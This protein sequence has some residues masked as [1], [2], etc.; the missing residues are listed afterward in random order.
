[1]PPSPQ[2][3]VL[4]TLSEKQ[5]IWPIEPSLRPW[6]DPP[7]AWQ[8]SSSTK[9]PRFLAMSMMASMLLGLPSMWTGMMALV[10]GV[11]RRS[12]SLGSSVRLSSISA[13]TGTT[14]AKIIAVYEAT[15]V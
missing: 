10:F 9:S 3:I 5:P 7:A 13:S 6:Y 15:K 14:P 1:M 4:K 12:M 11:M 2:V 8:A